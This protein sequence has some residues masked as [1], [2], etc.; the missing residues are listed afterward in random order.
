MDIKHVIRL[1][2]MAQKEALDKVAQQE[3]SKKFL[4]KKELEDFKEKLVESCDYIENEIVA[5]AKRGKRY[6]DYSIS[7]LG[8]DWE[9]RI[10]LL[11]KFKEWFKDFKINTIPEDIIDNYEAGT[12]TT[13]TAVRFSW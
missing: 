10:I 2:E 1:T 7:F 4:R 6:Y 9:K 3:K 12:Y 11:D 13:G 8:E 5:A